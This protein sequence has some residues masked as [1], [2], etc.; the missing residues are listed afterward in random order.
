MG[1]KHS[2]WWLPE[3]RD[4]RC[5]KV[6]WGRFNYPTLAEAGTPKVGPSNRASLRIRP[7]IVDDRGTIFFVPWSLMLCCFGLWL[8]LYSF[9]GATRDLALMHWIFDSRRSILYAVI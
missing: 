7:L 9:Q 2:F 5:G 8:M 1:S 6:D 4:A 3:G